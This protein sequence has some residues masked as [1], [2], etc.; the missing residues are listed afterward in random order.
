LLLLSNTLLDSWQVME[1]N[2]IFD[3]LVVEVSDLND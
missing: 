1:Q 2:V 3:R